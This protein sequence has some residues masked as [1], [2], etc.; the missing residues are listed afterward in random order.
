MRLIS[1]RRETYMKNE[2][3]SAMLISYR[4]GTL[5]KK[6]IMDAISLFVYRFPQK[7]YGWKEDDCSEFFSYFFP[8]ISKIIDSF[9]IT[10]APLEAYLVKTLTFQAKTFAVK[11]IAKEIN[12]KI[13]K[14]KEFWPYDNNELY[15]A[16]SNVNFHNEDANS[17]YFFIKKIFASD[18]IKHGCS[19]KT[20]KKRIII[21]VLKNMKN[22]PE[23][24]IPAIAKI[25]N[26]DKEWFYE[27]FSMI[28][29]KIENKIRRKN[30]LE[31]RRNRYFYKLYLL[32]ERLSNTEAEEEK[33]MYSSAVSKTKLCIDNITKK[34]NNMTVEPAHKDI[35]EVMGIPKGSVNS[36]LFYF[37]LYIEET[38]E[39]K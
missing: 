32:H 7:K 1:F 24:K 19:I 26:C 14:N 13:L 30:L 9:I 31:E 33:K 17:I 5:P 12:R 16:E 22:I 6:K 10:E 28:R 11:K 23:T 2:N 4:N 21:F 25:L 3:L 38:L 20:L 18:K 8:K 29:E 27:A 15:C 36:G 37:K 35:A 34:I 39:N